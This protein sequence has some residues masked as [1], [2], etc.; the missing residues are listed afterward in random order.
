MW[1]QEHGLEMDT[2]TA[3]EWV[4]AIACTRNGL[5]GCRGDGG[6]EILHA[7]YCALC[8]GFHP[9]QKHSFARKTQHAKQ[10][11]E[12]FLLQHRL[13]EVTSC[14]DQQHGKLKS[15]ILWQASETYIY[16]G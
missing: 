12:A 1:M 6:Y 16:Y 14:K 8:C 2:E 13:N 3:A 15:I 9:S 10:V 5:W 11:V 4:G 7:V